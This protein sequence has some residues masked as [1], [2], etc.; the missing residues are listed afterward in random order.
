MPYTIGIDLGGTNIKAGVV[1]P[2]GRILCRESIKTRAERK[3]V[4]IVR[5][6]GFLAQKVIAQAG[7]AQADV[8]A[9]GIGSPG[10]PDNE[11]GILVYTNNLPFA[12]VPMRAEIR[13]ILDLPVFI[14]ND[15]NCAA[16]AEH[17]SGGAVGTRH[18]VTVTLGTG[19]GGGIIIDGRIYSGFNHAG[20]ELGHMVLVQGGHPCTC[21][22]RGCFETYGS[23]T[24][25]V[26]DTVEAARRNPR[27]RMATLVDGD[28]S[29]IDA[30]IAFIAMREGDAAA[31]RVVED[32]LDHLGEGLANIV[33]AFM[34]EV[35]LLGGGVCHEGDALLVPVRER[36]DRL[37]YY[38]P[39]VRKTRIGLATMGNQAG[40]VGAAMMAL[41]CLDEG[42]AG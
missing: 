1:D 13:R 26:R 33:N 22:R 7:I 25:L 34:P 11:T 21:G 14:E 16:L 38:G 41:A 20:G 39:G 2:E 28:L 31:A 40:I 35:L 37:A 19:V 29:R 6:M 3:A 32:Y 8:A 42:M 17:V 36:V 5:D 18:S 24:A 30:R 15:A 9:I 4:E 23:A 27:S 10:T 12:N